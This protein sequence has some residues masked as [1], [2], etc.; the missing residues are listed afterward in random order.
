[1]ARSTDVLLDA[2][3][4]AHKFF[5]IDGVPYKCVPSETNNY[6]FKPLYKGTPIELDA[7]IVK[8]DSIGF[9]LHWTDKRGTK[10]RA[11]PFKF[12]TLTDI[13]SS[14]I[15]YS[16]AV[17]IGPVDALHYPINK[18]VSQQKG[19][20]VR[21]ARKKSVIYEDTH[22]GYHRFDI[23][24]KTNE[25]LLQAIDFIEKHTVCNQAGFDAVPVIIRRVII[26]GIPGTYTT[27]TGVPVTCTYFC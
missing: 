6:I 14:S 7:N 17:C 2:R 9:Y 11:R 3:L 19:R 8:A 20:L 5:L 13:R 12:C 23:S 10:H 22:D 27:R 24:G 18:K 1:M 15:T 21:A 16:I 26:S 25:E 4:L